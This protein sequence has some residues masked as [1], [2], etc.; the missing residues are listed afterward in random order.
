LLDSEGVGA[1]AEGASGAGGAGGQDP[2]VG[3][4]DARATVELAG[5]S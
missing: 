1:R 3:V 5:F 2:A 4:S